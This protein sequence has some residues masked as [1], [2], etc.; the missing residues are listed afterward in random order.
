M[1]MLLFCHLERNIVVIV[2]FELLI[3]HRACELFVSDALDTS[4]HGALT[5]RFGADVAKELICFESSLRSGSRSFIF[6]YLPEQVILSTA[7]LRYRHVEISRILL[8]VLPSPIQDRICIF[9]AVLHTIV[10]FQPYHWHFIKFILFGVD[11]GGLLFVRF[12]L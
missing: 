11:M 5:H 9:L 10:Q 2:S 4:L 8:G 3:F 1:M 6:S 7:S 12:I